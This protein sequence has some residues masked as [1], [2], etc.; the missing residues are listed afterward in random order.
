MHECMSEARV[1]VAVVYIYTA[2]YV[3]DG[4]GSWTKCDD[5]NSMSYLTF[6]CTFLHQTQFEV[7]CT[8]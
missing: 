5:H 2:R 7:R 3:V 6:E 4:A 8:Y 1:L